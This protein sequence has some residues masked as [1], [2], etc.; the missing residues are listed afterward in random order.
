MVSNQRLLETVDAELSADEVFRMS[1]EIL[2]RGFE[3]ISDIIAEAG[4]VNIDF[5][6]IRQVMQNAGTVLIGVGQAH[7]E[8]R[9][10]IAAE[11]AVSSPLL[12]GKRIGGATG[13]IVKVSAPPDFMMNE[14]DAAMGVIKEEAFD[15]RII[16]GLVYKDN[17]EPEDAVIVTVLAAG[18]GTQA[19]QLL[20]PPQNT[21]PTR[22]HGSDNGWREG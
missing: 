8:N 14:L 7:G 4:E 12:D 3:A 16:F 13:L 17:P 18:V 1:D 21:L 22:I 19:D 10:R 9:A 11:K 2:L 6:D 15:A 20:H 5:S